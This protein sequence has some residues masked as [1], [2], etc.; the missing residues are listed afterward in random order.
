MTDW[1]DIPITAGFL[2]VALE[3]CMSN[4][5]LADYNLAGLMDLVAGAIENEA[6]IKAGMEPLA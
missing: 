1:K 6:R 2:V 5:L 4:D 3:N